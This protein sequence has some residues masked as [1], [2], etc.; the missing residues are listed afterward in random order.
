MRHDADM[1]WPR[2]LAIGGHDDHFLIVDRV[3][4]DYVI[5]V[6]AKNGEVMSVYLRSDDIE[7]VIQF[8]S[9]QEE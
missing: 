3:G 8:I 7:R 5:G 1:D 2:G 9:Y 4:A 6:R